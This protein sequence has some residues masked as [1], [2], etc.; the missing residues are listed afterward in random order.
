VSLDSYPAH[1]IDLQDIDLKKFTDK[2]NAA[3]RFQLN[4]DHLEI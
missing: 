4:Q 1:G 3:L 2:A